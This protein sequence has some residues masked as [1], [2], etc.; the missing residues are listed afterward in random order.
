M[1][2]TKIR[3]ELSGTHKGEMQLDESTGWI[4]KYELTEQ[5]AGKMIIK[6]QPRSTGAQ[7]WPVAMEAVFRIEPV[8]TD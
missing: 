8:S 7:S 5:A 1:G 3:Y 6:G 2:E 4:V